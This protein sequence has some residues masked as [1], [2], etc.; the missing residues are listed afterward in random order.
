M[1]KQF[2][3]FSSV[4]FGARAKGIVDARW[5]T[6]WIDADGKKTVKAR[7]VAEGYQDPDLRG[8]E[9]IPLSRRMELIAKCPYAPQVNGIPQILVAFGN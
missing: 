8:G 5:V 2:G 1:W 4:D 6:T 9:K 3:V 7:L